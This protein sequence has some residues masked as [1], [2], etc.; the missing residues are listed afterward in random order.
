MVVAARSCFS[1]NSE[2]SAF[3]TRK[4]FSRAKAAP[5]YEPDTKRLEGLRFANGAVRVRRVRNLPAT[6]PGGCV[7]EK[8]CVSET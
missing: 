1:S 4:A 7:M 3:R 8:I 2:S 6:S 5:N